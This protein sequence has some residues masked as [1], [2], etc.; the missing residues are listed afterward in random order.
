MLHR[1]FNSVG[2]SI[3]CSWSL[4]LIWK[5]LKHLVLSSLMHS[6]LS[7]IDPHHIAYKPRR[8]VQSFIKHTPCSFGCSY[9]HCW[10][11]ELRTHQMR[12]HSHDSVLLLSWVI[13][14]L[15]HTHKLMSGYV[16][17]FIITILFWDGLGQ[18]WWAWSFFFLAEEPQT[19]RTFKPW[20]ITCHRRIMPLL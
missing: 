4:S 17:P 10:S 5:S 8:W 15:D 7:G 18:I 14:L 20:N 3:N 1:G 9:W 11:P 19:P 16:N 12:P 2:H 13:Q 6:N